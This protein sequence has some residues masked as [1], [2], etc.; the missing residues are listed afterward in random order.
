MVGSELPPDPETRKQ[1]LEENKEKKPPELEE[2]EEF[3]KKTEE[4]KR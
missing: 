4:R 1:F 3:L 2:Y